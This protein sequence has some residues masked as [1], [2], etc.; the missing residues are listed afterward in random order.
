MCDVCQVCLSGS[1][2]FLRSEKSRIQYGIRTMYQTNVDDSM[3][4]NRISVGNMTL[5]FHSIW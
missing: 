1:P 5:R 3:T 2:S 4:I